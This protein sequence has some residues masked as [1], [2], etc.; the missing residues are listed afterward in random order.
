MERYYLAVNV[1]NPHWREVTKKEFV[2]AE[3]AAGFHNTMGLPDELATGGFS[4]GGVR[5]RV[6]CVREEGGDVQGKQ[7]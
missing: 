2:Q 3:R 7:A 5:G 1:E 4:G 6:E